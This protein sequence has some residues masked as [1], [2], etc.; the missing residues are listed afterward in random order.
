[1]VRA[2]HLLSGVVVLSLSWPIGMRI[3]FLAG[4]VGHFVWW[5]RQP[6]GHVTRIELSPGG[7]CTVYNDPRQ[8][9]WQ[10]RV[11]RAV[12]YPF[13]V[14]LWVREDTDESVHALLLAQDAIDESVFHGLRAQIHQRLLPPMKAKTR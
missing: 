6:E 14:Q 3:G 2:M 7:E 12:A 10:G 8:M 4:I 13:F 1:M 9:I 11:V 5:W